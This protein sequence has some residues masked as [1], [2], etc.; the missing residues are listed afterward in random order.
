[1]RKASRWDIAPF[2][3]IFSLE[4]DAR[5][6]GRDFS[7]PPQLEGSN[8]GKLILGVGAPEGVVGRSDWSH[9]LARLARN[10]PIFIL[11]NCTYTLYK[12]KKKTL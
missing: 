12:K 10:C 3:V 4:G 5:T 2:A 9:A 1:M 8:H 6:T 7:G 11:K